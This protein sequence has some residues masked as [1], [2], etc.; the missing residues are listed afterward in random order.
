M[1]KWAFLVFLISGAT[2]QIDI[3]KTPEERKILVITVLSTYRVSEIQRNEEIIIP[4][5]YSLEASS[6]TARKI[7]QL[8]QVSTFPSLSLLATEDTLKIT[9]W[10]SHINTL[11]HC[12][13]MLSI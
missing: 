2:Q 1:Q 4:E 13:S 5:A 9:V 3:L 6:H 7:Q 8:F 10:T 11:K 12:S